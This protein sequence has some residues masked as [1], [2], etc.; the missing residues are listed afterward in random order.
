MT[1]SPYPDRIVPKAGY[2][3]ELAKRTLTN[4]YNQR[5]GW[6]D[7]AHRALDVAVAHTLW[8]S[9]KLT[10]PLLIGIDSQTLAE[11]TLAC[12]DRRTHTALGLNGRLRLDVLAYVNR[13]YLN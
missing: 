10:H 12:G 13:H 2:E 6:L 4:L 7:A 3:K 11:S 1:T 8:R 5:P 9:L